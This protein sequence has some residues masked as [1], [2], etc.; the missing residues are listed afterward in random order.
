MVK[1]KSKREIDPKPLSWENMAWIKDK[2]V[3]FFNKGVTLSL[4]VCG[5]ILLYAQVVK[6]LE[7]LKEWPDEDI[8][9]AAN[10]IFEENSLTDTQKKS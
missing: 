5:K 6:N 8:Y 10:I 3:E 1:L 4:F 9:E 2:S 7:D